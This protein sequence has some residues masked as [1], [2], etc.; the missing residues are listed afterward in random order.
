MGIVHAPRPKQGASGARGT[1]QRERR[2]SETPAREGHGANAQPSS[3]R[4]A[5]EAAPEQNGH[6]SAADCNGSGSPLQRA[7]GG[8]MKGGS[9]VLSN[10][11]RIAAAASGSRTDHRHQEAANSGAP[12]DG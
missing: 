11:N 9:S 12:D 10:P 6:S 2:S 8:S 3:S 1:E 7:G 5:E 4:E